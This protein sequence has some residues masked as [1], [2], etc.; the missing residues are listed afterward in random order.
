M[1]RIVYLDQNRKNIL[2]ED[3]PSFEEIIK[4]LHQLEKDISDCA[5]K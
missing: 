5:R 4:G 3:I 1:K 2:F